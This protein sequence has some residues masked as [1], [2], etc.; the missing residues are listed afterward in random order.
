MLP[1]FPIIDGQVRPYVTTTYAQALAVLKGPL[2][3]EK[4]VLYLVASLCLSRSD[5]SGYKASRPDGVS[6]LQA[7]DDCLN[8]GQIQ[9]AVLL[10]MCFAARSAVD[11]IDDSQAMGDML[12]VAL[13]DSEAPARDSQCVAY[14]I[15][16]M[17]RSCDHVGGLAKSLPRNKDHWVKTSV[18]IRREKAKQTSVRVN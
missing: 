13:G 16:R 12:K 14:L 10:Q 7:F 17:S 8:T 4:L 6:A 1:V 9:P 18:R 5:V 11:V 3:A 2:P 15:Y